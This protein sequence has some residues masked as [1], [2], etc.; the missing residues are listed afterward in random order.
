MLYTDER[1]PP[2]STQLDQP[3]PSVDG[4]T[5]WICQ[6]GVRIVFVI[7]ASNSVLTMLGLH[8]TQDTSARQNGESSEFWSTTPQ[9]RM[10]LQIEG[11]IICDIKG[12]PPGPHRSVA[13]RLGRR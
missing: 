1:S 10:P 9:V 5:F 8:R 3:G 11:P 2:T 7:T 6:Q 12:R 4:R 13:A